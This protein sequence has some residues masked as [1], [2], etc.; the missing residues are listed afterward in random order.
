M[1][2][3]DQLKANIDAL[4][5]Q[6]ASNSDIQGYLD[7]LKGQA[8]PQTS[9]PQ[10]TQQSP[11]ERIWSNLA[12]AG[13]TVGGTLGG[14]QIGESIGTLAG[15]G[16]TKASEVTGLPI[17]PGG[18][19]LFHKAL[20][21]E[22]QQYDLSAPTPL[23]TIGDAAKIALTVAGPKIG[24][25]GTALGR[26]GANT[27]LGAGVGTANAVSEGQGLGGTIKQAAIGGVTGGALSTA[28]E[29]VS[30]FIRNAPKWFTKAALP[31]LDNQNIPYALEN[32]KL[33]SS[34]ETLLGDSKQAINSY[35]GQVQSILSHPEFKAVAENTDSIVSNALGE[36]PNSEYTSQTLFKNAKKIAPEVQGLIKKMEAGQADIQELNTI[37]KA[38]DSATKSVY[39]SINRPPESKALGSALAG[40][41]RD[42]VKT[43]APETVPI[44]DNYS[45]EIALNKALQTAVEKN[46]LRPTLKDFAVAYAGYE[47]GGVRGAV[48][49]L[50]AERLGGSTGGKLLM[51]KGAQAITPALPTLGSV[52][53]GLKT[54]IIGA[55]NRILSQ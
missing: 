35:E 3:Q 4:Q 9:A 54:P 21:G 29:G 5:K 10:Q 12:S 27:V 36:F 13:N 55:V 51:A 48:A 47:A 46:N 40:A 42:Y 22:S 49:A 20:P 50:A 15:Y 23:Q 19:G 52:A 33:G 39:T 1:L 34:V 53:R 18:S 37:R 38:L 17:A 32:T 8:A 14:K 6:G 7:S 44:F 2:T 45:K 16:L 24:T 43:N 11:S 30:A 26:I 25:G 41:I 31:K 28:A